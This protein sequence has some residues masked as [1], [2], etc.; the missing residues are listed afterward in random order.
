[1]RDE[2]TENAIKEG[3]IWMWFH[4]WQKNCM[5]C[6]AVACAVRL[7]VCSMLIYR[8]L[9]FAFAYNPSSVWIITGIFNEQL[10][11]E[12]AMCHKMETNFWKITNLFQSEKST[13]THKRS[14]TKRTFPCALYMRL[15]SLPFSLCTDA[16]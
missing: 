5:L 4:F 7:D 13:R 2:R 9:Y 11:K 10:N 16:F 1:M 12:W 3:H 8:F 15:Y 14:L 6:R